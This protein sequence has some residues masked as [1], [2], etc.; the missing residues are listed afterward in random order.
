[1]ENEKRIK[2]PREMRGSIDSE[3]VNRV[4]SRMTGACNKLVNRFGTTRRS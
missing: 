2:I 3:D 1:M 4:I